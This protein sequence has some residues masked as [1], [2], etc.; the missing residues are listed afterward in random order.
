MELGEGGGG[1]HGGIVGGKSD[2][3][4][5]YGEVAACGFG[6]DAAAELGVGG[7]A[8]RD[9]EGLGTVVLGGGEGGAG[10]VV[11]DG[12][13][14]AGDEV[15]GFGVEEFKGLGESFGVAGFGVGEAGFAEGAGAGF[16]AGLHV[17]E[18]GVAADGGFDA[19]EGQ[20]VS[21]KFGAGGVFVLFEGSFAGELGGGVA[22]GLGFDLGE[23]KRNGF[24]V[25]VGGEGVHPGAAGVGKAEELGDFVVGFT[26]GV[27]EGL[28]DV[29]VAPG[30][31][32]FC[33]EVEMGVAAADYE[34]EKRV[35][36]GEGGFGVHEDGVDV[37]FKVVDSDEGFIGG[38]G[39][40][41]SE[42]D[43]DQQCAGETGAFGYG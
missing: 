6:G 19:A 15:E 33:G 37:A 9:E 35:G 16:D 2:G 43:A 21:P 20:I 3:G 8:S 32:G 41:L 1:D 27:V 24:G 29:A 17:M 5:G 7:D 26:G 4:E 31:A 28:A 14:E 38:E 12:R 30:V 22:G 18:L 34:R 13:L 40:S 11:G 39:E 36:V 23:G 42:G 25:A 10:E